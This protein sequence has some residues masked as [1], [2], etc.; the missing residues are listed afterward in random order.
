MTT[1]LRGFYL[2]KID[3]YKHEL[4]SANKRGDF[5]SARYWNAQLLRA[6]VKLNA[7]NKAFNNNKAA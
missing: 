5:N 4:I 2:T 7:V 6:L 1:D 3:T